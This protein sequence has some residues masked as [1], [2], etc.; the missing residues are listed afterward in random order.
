MRA[1]IITTVVAGVIVLLL[2]LPLAV[3]EYYVQLLNL[4]LIGAL[5]ALS[6]NLLFGYTG[7]LSFGQAAFF[8]VGAYSLALLMK[9]AG[10]SFAA[11][12]LLSL[13]IT[14]VA[15]GAIGY[16]CVRVTEWS[17][18]ILTLAFGQFLFVIASKWYTLTAGDD[19]IQS[20]F[21]PPALGSSVRYYYFT[22]A[23]VTAAALALWWLVHTPFGYTLQSIREN[24]RRSEAIG[25]NIRWYRWLAFV[26]SGGFAG[27]AGC[28][29]TTF[30][31]AVAPTELEWTK[32]ADP[33]VM[34][35]LGGQH[36]F[37]GPVVGAA[38]FTFLQFYLGRHTLYWALAMGVVILFVVRFMRGGVGGFFWQHVSA[39]E[40]RGAGNAASR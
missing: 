23:V 16:F 14:A 10:F 28:L 33:V 1:R 29:F 34:T 5:F 39:H 15:A 31:W 2:L 32:S 18:S 36:V 7:L 11:A 19:G 8:G 17:F 38:I 35:L 9:K 30:N 24:A 25:I 22:L 26:V 40:A 13:P 27:V 4:F 20:V 21:P 12:F 37:G 6:F 3:R